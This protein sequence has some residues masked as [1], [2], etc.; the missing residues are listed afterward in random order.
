MKRYFKNKYN[1]QIREVGEGWSWGV[2]FFG[3]FYYLYKGM[4]GKGLMYL[5]VNIL[6]VW[7]IISPILISFWMCLNFNDEYE[8]Y[9][10]DNGFEL[11]ENK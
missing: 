9:L 2:F 6:L 1:G 3:I 5:L 8:K 4:I 10:L 11:M 7:T